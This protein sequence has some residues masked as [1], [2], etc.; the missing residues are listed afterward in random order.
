MNRKLYRFDRGT[1]EV[2]FQQGSI[3]IVNDTALWTL[4]EGTVKENTITLVTW[5]REQYQ[6]LLGKDLD[7][8]DDSLAVEIWG[9][10]YFEYYLL[11][12]KEL[13]RLQ[14][15]NDLLEPLL[16]KSD[17]IDCG[18]AGLDNNRKLWDMLAPHRNFIL[19]MLPGKINPGQKEAATSSPV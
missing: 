2:L 7:I 11:I 10:V 15:L 5:I 13:V 6:A 18:E 12:L 4:L 19:G 1:V 17:V 9:H 3:H 16:A 8:T 14:L